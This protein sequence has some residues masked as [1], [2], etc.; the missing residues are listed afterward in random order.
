MT[1]LQ[2]EYFL[3]TARTMNFHQAAA[4][5][6]VSQQVLSRQIQSLEQELDLKLFDRS[7]KRNLQLTEAGKLLFDKWSPVVADMNNALEQARDIEKERDNTIILGIHAVSWIVDHAV[8]IL[9]KFRE[10]NNKVRVETKVAGTVALEQFMESGDI[11]MLMTF[12]TELTAAHTKYCKLGSIKI[13]PAIMM[14]KTHPLADRKQLDIPDLEKENIYLLKN[15]F[16]KDASK[17]VLQDFENA[18]VSPE[19]IEYFDNAESMEAKLMMGEGVCIG[20]DILFRNH[21]RLKYFPYHKT[22]EE[23]YDLVL[24]WKDTKYEKIAKQFAKL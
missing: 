20:L 5:K 18:G 13:H 16:S 1:F 2:I 11:N 17:R 14:A 10:K 12:S 15:S 21:D 24:C 22:R 7:N 3:E 6:F 19:K 4:N 23:E 9:Q 8:E